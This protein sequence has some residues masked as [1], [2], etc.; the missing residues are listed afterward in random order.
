MRRLKRSGLRLFHVRGACGLPLRSDRI[1]VV[2]VW[3]RADTQVMSKDRVENPRLFSAGEAS[4]I[5]RRRSGSA[6]LFLCLRLA[7]S[8][9]PAYS[10]SLMHIAENLGAIESFPLRCTAN[11]SRTCGLH[12]FV[13]RRVRPLVR[14]FRQTVLH[15]I[16]MDVVEMLVEIFFMPDRVFPESRLP[17]L[18]PRRPSRSSPRRSVVPDH[19][20]RPIAE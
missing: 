17:Y 13:E 7:L 11:G 12:P 1:I 2:L 9:E 15:R 8:A 6:G 18:F 5:D 20:P 14:T 3:K 10:I 4:A 19:P 16:V